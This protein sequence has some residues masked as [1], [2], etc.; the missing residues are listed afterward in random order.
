MSS[1]STVTPA[2]RNPPLFT[3][4]HNCLLPDSQIGKCSPKIV[5]VSFTKL[6]TASNSVH[7]ILFHAVFLFLLQVTAGAFHVEEV[8]KDFRD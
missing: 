3:P 4:E 2:A 5:T 7:L 8:L 6:H 1:T